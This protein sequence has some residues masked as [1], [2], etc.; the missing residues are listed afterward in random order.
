M[1]F[2]F[3]ISLLVLIVITSFLSC[4][5]N[6]SDNINIDDHHVD[7]TIQKEDIKPF[8]IFYQVAVPVEMAEI[9]EKIGH[10]FSKD[11]LNNPGNENKYETS[12]DLALNLGVYGVDL[13]YCK[14]MD[15]QQMAAQY[16]NV[17]NDVASDLGIPGD[18][19]SDLSSSF[20]RN[21]NRKDSLTLVMN[22]LYKKTDTYLKERGNDALSSLIIL[23]GWIEAMY[24]SGGILYQVDNETDLIN[25]ILSQKYSLNNLIALLSQHSDNLIVAKYLIFLNVLKRFYDKIELYYPLG[26]VM[27][28][29]DS[30]KIESNTIKLEYSSE[31]LEEIISMIRAIRFEIVN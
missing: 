28:D 23:G 29:K 10:S 21:I 17:V 24:I 20:E 12:Q 16:F 13:S 27:V 2:K 7:Y 5:E 31:D 9:F 22:D 4:N 30:R 18:Y 8:S 6:E 11:L 25:K 1:D 19:F 3:G 14:I 15:Q 26:D